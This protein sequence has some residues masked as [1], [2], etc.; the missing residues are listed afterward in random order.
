MVLQ[1][2]EK[3]I[4]PTKMK[5]CI[6][7]KFNEPFEAKFKENIK[8]GWSQKINLLPKQYINW[9]IT[10]YKNKPK[11][12]EQKTEKVLVIFCQDIIH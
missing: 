4:Q 5:N 8:Q 11:K 10:E 6:V 9:F 3:K 7:L 12:V 1:T 2:G